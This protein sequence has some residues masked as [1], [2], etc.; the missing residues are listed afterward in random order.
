MQVFFVG[1]CACGSR[2]SRYAVIWR[3]AMME[4]IEKVLVVLLYLP[5]VLLPLGLIVG[6]AFIEARRQKN[7]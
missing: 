4:I 3:I 7:N 6:Y 5:F 1:L 2:L